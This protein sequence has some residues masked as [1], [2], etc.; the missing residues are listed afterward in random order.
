MHRSIMIDCGDDEADC[1]AHFHRGSHHA[2]AVDCPEG[3]DCAIEIDCSD[4]DCDCT[5][6]GDSVDCADLHAAQDSGD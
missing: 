6:N 4:G 5:L 3:E 1:A 2:M